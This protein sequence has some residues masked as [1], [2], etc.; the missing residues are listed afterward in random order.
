M[1]RLA[2]QVWILAAGNERGGAAAH[3][4]VLA[5]TI[6]ASG[7]EA[8]WTVVLAGDGHLRQ[9]L[10]PITSGLR[11]VD[12][13]ARQAAR[14][15]RAMIQ[16]QRAA[17]HRVLLHAHGPRMN[18]LAWLATRR[19]D[20]PWTSTLHSDLYRD[21][22]ASRWK[23]AVLP[24]I[25]LFCLRRTCGVFVISPEFASRVPGQATVFVPNA[26]D[27]PSLP[28]ESGHYRRTLRDLLGIAD[29]ASVIGIAARFD[30][31][32][33]IA[34]LLR[35][36]PRLPDTVHLAIAGDGAQRDLLV[37]LAAELGITT[38]THFLGYIDWIH[39]FYAGLDVHVLASVSEGTP[40]SLLEAGFFGVPNVGTDIP[41]IR[42]LLDPDVTGEL[43]AVGD[44]AG[45]AAAVTALIRDKAR[46]RHMAARF[47][48]D[49]LPQYTPHEMMAAY[50]RGYRQFAGWNVNTT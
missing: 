8:E 30:P 5:Q 33:D 42:R 1:V 37:G 14:Q 19:S 11:T 26:I 10:A 22:L 13:S 31:V 20:V 45:L 15:L 47:A 21:Y 18:V 36:M 17:G 6:A 49:V 40:T 39:E 50:S 9:R 24:H 16:A 28:Y 32:K 29:N 35:A 25:N 2:D 41:G 44:S 38:R 12:G 48:R 3:L 4:H 23:T 7:L 27:V 46:A 43:F 34:T